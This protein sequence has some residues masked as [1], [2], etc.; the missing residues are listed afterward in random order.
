MSSCGTTGQGSEEPTRLI[1]GAF[2]DG[3][4]KQEPGLHPLFATAPGREVPAYALA[5]CTDGT[6]QTIVTDWDGDGVPNDRE[7]ATGR[8]PHVA[9]YPRVTVRTG[10]PLTMEIE[11]RREGQTKVYE[12]T[13]NEENTKTTKTENMDETHY[14]KINQK[15]TPYVVKTA[16]SDAGSDANS[17]GYHFSDELSINNSFSLG[18]LKLFEMAVMTGMSKKNSKSENWS[19]ANSFNRSSMSEKTVFDNVNFVDNMDGS[20]IVLKDSKVMDMENR[21]RGSEISSDTISY[22][23]NA[24][25][26]SAAFY[27]KNESLDM[28]VRI[29]GVQCTV[30]LKYPTGRLDALSTFPL[31]FEDGRPFEVEI[32]GGEETPP[33][34]VTVTGLGTEKIR[35]A[36]KNGLVPVVSIFSSD[37]TLVD[38]SSYQPGIENLSQVEEGAKSRTAVIRI[39]APNRRD[40]YRVAAFDVNGSAMAPGI[41][42]KK[43]LFN[44]FRSQLKGGES[45]EHDALGNGLTVTRE[46]L[47][48]GE[49]G[50]G[51]GKDGRHV[52]SYSGNLT[53][54][55]WD[56]FSTE[57]KMSEDEYGKPV[58]IETIKRI[59]NERDAFGEY[60]T[61]KYNP[62]DERDNPSYDDNESLSEDELLKTRYWVVLHNGKYYEGD[63]ND[64][65]W[66][67]DRYEIVLFNVQDFREH[68][69]QMVYTPL[70]SGE[71]F[72]LDTRWNA[73]SNGTAELARA[74][75][76][77]SVSRGDVVRLDV[78]LKESRFLFDGSVSDAAGAGVPRPV[79]P[80]N[81]DSPQAW[82][83]FRYTFE[84]EHG[85][86]NGIP[87]SFG[88]SVTGGVNGL[89]VRIDASKNARYYS[90]EISDRKDTGAAPR[91]VMVTAE[92]LDKAGREVYLTSKT[93]DISGASLGVIRASEYSVSVRAHGVDYGVDV[94]TRS[95]ANGQPCSRATVTGA[96]AELP[97][98]N[99]TFS[100]MSLY[101][102]LVHVRVGDI[103]NTEYF[104]IRCHGPLNYEGGAAQ[105]RE[106]RGHS[107]LNIVELEHPFGNLAEAGEP[108]VYRVEVFSVNRNCYDGDQEEEGDLARTI[109]SSGTAF[110]NVEYETYRFQRVLAPYRWV[111]ESERFLDSTAA[112]RSFGLN[113]IDLEVN[114]NEG[115]GWWRLK[116]ANDDTGAN[117][118]TIDCRFTSIIEDYEGQHF[119]IYFTPP[120]GQPDP[121]HNVFRSSDSEVDLYV[122]TVAESR[123]RD[124][125]WMKNLNQG[126]VYSEDANCVVTGPGVGDFKTYWNML[127]ETDA[128]RFE[129]TL[130]GWRI[131]S[132]AD[133]ASGPAGLVEKEVSDAAYFF[134]P[135]E[136]RKYLVAALIDE[137]DR[138][139]PTMPTGLDFPSFRAEPGRECIHVNGIESR[140][141]EF[142][143]VWCKKF[144][145]NGSYDLPLT[146][147]SI[148]WDAERAAPAEGDRYNWRVW[149]AYPGEGGACALTA[150]DCEPNQ[151]YVIAVVGKSTPLHGTSEARF[152]G[153]KNGSGDNISF[154]MPYPADAPQESPYLSLGV[155]KRSIIVNLNAVSEQCRYIIRWREKD[156]MDDPWSVYDTY[157]GTDGSLSWNGCSF[158][159]RNCN[160]KTVYTVKAC[161]VT[162]NNLQG[163]A[164]EQ[165]IETG[166]EGGMVWS[167]IWDRPLTQRI[168]PVDRTSK[169]LDASLQVSVSQLP[170]GAASYALDGTI[171]CN[172]FTTQ[173][174]GYIL[175]MYR[176][177][178]KTYAFSIT[179][180]ASER[181]ATLAA[182]TPVKAWLGIFTMMK[183]KNFNVKGT[184]RAFNSNGAD[185]TPRD[186]V[187]GKY[188]NELTWEFQDC[189][190][191]P[192][193]E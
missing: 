129:E 185:I 102:G 46:G 11:Y 147:E 79:S 78:Y 122:R 176:P 148:G 144:N 191:P 98:G 1:A 132:A 152:A 137:P 116:L 3:M 72:K 158:T 67:G 54:N 189:P 155:D 99:F 192:L 113:A 75:M 52:Y 31:Q 93:R 77:G 170:A 4:K 86:P 154:I 15:T 55:D 90:L 81:A 142:F 133:Y 22:V 29:S 69:E 136:Q 65:I 87:E 159:I 39:V 183:Y 44:I 121:H 5:S 114:F 103:P 40:L 119:V 25:R 177:I 166:T 173:T 53:G 26:I 30:L 138:L 64:P 57:I 120:S 14:A 49:A 112:V 101:R 179:A 145:R 89:V 110:V 139:V 43:A 16:E 157:D 6:G 71:L 140:Y 193:K 104:L 59:G 125:F 17:Y 32:G 82:W 45:W 172:L 124:T 171:T 38:D 73:L 42:L 156:R 160:P 68:F 182:F 181:L 12:E 187:T 134:S 131:D 85:E 168:W 175:G 118:R 165:E 28:P 88:H 143:E 50:S 126:P 146:A 37:M 76:L 19:F 60:I 180:P 61:Q 186:P 24:G 7:I 23:P 117:G 8:N 35:S 174:P 63:I 128:S 94:E 149:Y 96:T 141:A 135:L 91:S 58:Y 47:W 109:S 105:V 62:F 84:P 51:T 9:D 66:A 34:A 41:S 18:V 21:Y 10:Q 190:Q 48:W 27:F 188:Q 150:P 161:A 153:D 33:F 108:G 164:A 83:D 184:I 92:E 2:L 13:I 56:Y 20:G 107:G 74:K 130:S 80:G 178:V 163:P 97:S 115:S 36:L 100:A 106:V 167:F 169:C 95:F 127:P 151:Y 70:Q 111:P 123:Y 162:L